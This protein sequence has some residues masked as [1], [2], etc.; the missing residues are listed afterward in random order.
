MILPSSP[1][2]SQIVT[3]SSGARYIYYSSINNW[4]CIDRIES[5]SLIS[6]S[7]DGIITPQIAELVQQ[8]GSVIPSMKIYPNIG[9]YY[10]MLRGN[11]LISFSPENNNIRIELNQSQ[12]T[13]QLSTNACS[14]D[15]GLIG[16]QGPD[17]RNGRLGP[18]EQSY[19][20]IVDGNLLMLE[21]PVESPLGTPISL[22][23]Y[24]GSEIEIWIYDNDTW[25]LKSGDIDVE[26]SSISY[27][28]GTVSV[29]LVGD[30]NGAWK[31]KIRQ[32]GPN[33]WDGV[34]GTPFM[35]VHTS[36]ANIESAIAVTAMRHSIYDLF[37]NTNTLDDDSFTVAH[38]RVAEA[39]DHKASFIGRF[40]NSLV[41][42]SPNRCCGDANHD[43]RRWKFALG[44]T[45]RLA[46]S[47]LPS[48]P[49]SPL[50]LPGW[51]PDYTCGNVSFMWWPGLPDPQI[52]VSPDLPQRCC[53]ED[54]FFCPTLGA[55]PSV[56]N[57]GSWEPS[58]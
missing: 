7:M 10:Y 4:I 51:T 17:G 9:A 32:R 19:I 36:M 38:L 35:T 58:T 8:L 45:V 1:I 12:L 34:D 48:P 3:D 15:R 24:G 47:P 44:D 27:C 57:R 16:T 49:Y 21:A 55:S 56:L 40:A 28:N 31:A 11:H 41:A 18:S 46:Y 30:W 29:I 5:N 22:R 43:I 33:G 14:G 54:F 2:D 37:M 20:P 13:H 42:V 6:R 26:Q 25:E 39:E 23:L 50:R 52:T 53:Q